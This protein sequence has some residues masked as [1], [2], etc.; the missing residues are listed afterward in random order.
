MLLN[1]NIILF[2]KK[3]NYQVLNTF[4]LLKKTYSPLRSAIRLVLNI[5][6]LKLFL[7]IKYQLMEYLLFQYFP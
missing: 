4:I 3:F 2:I 1:H 5:I 7:F 6:F